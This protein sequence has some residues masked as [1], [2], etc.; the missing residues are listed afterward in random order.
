MTTFGPDLL[1]KVLDGTKDM[2]RRPL[3]E[4]DVFFP[5]GWTVGKPA[6]VNLK[7]GGPANGGRSL[8]KYEVGRT[9]AIQPGRGKSAVARFELIGLRV[10]RLQEITREDA[11]REG[12]PG[13]P[14]MVDGGLVGVLKP[15]D[16][17]L[18]AWNRIYIDRPHLQW[19]ANPKVAVLTFKLCEVINARSL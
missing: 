8:I 15:V 13:Y 12:F 16:H 3:K 11:I 5:R 9:Y 1:P 4:G 7:F 17:F 6:I 10:E 14:L 19:S 2:T 18:Q